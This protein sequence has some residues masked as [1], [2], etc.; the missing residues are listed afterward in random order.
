MAEKTI[1]ADSP[2]A[3]AWYAAE[4]MPVLQNGETLR[5]AREKSRI[6]QSELA[7]ACGLLQGYISQIEHGERPLPEETALK[8]WEALAELGRQTSR[9]E[10]LVRL[11]NAH[12]VVTERSEWDVP[13]ETEST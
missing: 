13:A 12:V 1:A 4:L 3:G 6:S 11:Q 5:D 10:I 9:S 7:R 2:T 8:I